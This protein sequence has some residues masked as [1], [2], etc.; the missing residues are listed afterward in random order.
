LRALLGASPACALLYENLHYDRSGLSQS[1]LDVA[2][3][4]EHDASVFIQRVRAQR[5]PGRQAD[6]SATPE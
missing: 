3:S 6:P 2:V 4:S 1:P 5:A